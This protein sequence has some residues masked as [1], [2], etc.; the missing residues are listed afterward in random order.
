MH[1]KEQVLSLYHLWISGFDV[2]SAH[3]ILPKVWKF[4]EDH[5]LK[6]QPYFHILLEFLEII[7]DLRNVI[8]S[9][10]VYHLRTCDYDKRSYCIAFCG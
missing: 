4:R 9:L 3:W 10:D 5:D 8:L 1:R 2:I 7:F 6:V